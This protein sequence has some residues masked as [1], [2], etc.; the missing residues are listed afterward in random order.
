MV[1]ISAFAVALLLAGTVTAQEA[2]TQR[3]ARGPVTVVATVLSGWAPDAPLRVR[4]TL[5]THS[6]ALDAIALDQSVVVRRSD[7]T[8]MAPVAVEAFGGGHHRQA[9]LTFPAADAEG[10]V[11]V[12]VKD[13]GGVPERVFTFARPAAR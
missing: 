2:L 4:I 8:E 5:D 1:R 6:V 3:D 10:P 7:G 12:V 13:V 11:R 9:I